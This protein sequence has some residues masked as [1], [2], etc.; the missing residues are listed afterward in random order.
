MNIENNVKLR[1]QFISR[2]VHRECNHLNKTTERLFIVPFSLDR[3]KT[4]NNDD[5]LSE[6][7]EAFVSRFARLQDTL[8]D[9]LIPQLLN[10]LGERPATVMDN[11]DSIYSINP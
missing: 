3:A 10:A 11:L 8:G 7:V 9:K 1:L 4:I 6:C 5:D 2:V